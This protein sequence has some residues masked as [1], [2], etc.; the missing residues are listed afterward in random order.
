ML[1]WHEDLDAARDTGL[2][3]DEAGPFESEDHLVD[4]GWGDAE[5]TLHLVAI[6]DARGCRRR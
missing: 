2:A 3:A 1:W 4:R 6:A 5:V